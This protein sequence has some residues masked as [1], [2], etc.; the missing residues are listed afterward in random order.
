MTTFASQTRFKRPKKVKPKAKDNHETKDENRK[1]RITWW[2]DIWL[3]PII[4][5]LG[6]LQWVVF[7]T[8]GGWLAGLGLVIAV[9]FLA[10]TAGL[11]FLRWKYW[12]TRKPIYLVGDS[13]KYGKHLI[14]DPNPNYISPQTMAKYRRICRRWRQLW[15]SGHYLTTAEMIPSALN[16]TNDEL[17]NA[18]R[19][20]RTGRFDDRPWWPR[21]QDSLY[22][23]N[24]EDGTRYLP[25]T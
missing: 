15:E 1:G 8:I 5:A 19:A 18:L 17:S 24:F 20:W 14:Y 11:F 6:L 16:T 25:T 13:L 12:P 21:F 10:I 22:F 23:R 9:I 2:Y 3:V 4:I 7:F